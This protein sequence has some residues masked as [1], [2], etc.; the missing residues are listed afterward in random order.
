[1]IALA[2]VRRAN[3][4]GRKFVIGCATFSSSSSSS[5]R[6]AS[7]VLLLIVCAWGASGTLVAGPK[8]LQ[9][10]KNWGPAVRPT[11]GHVWPLPRTLVPFH[12]H[13]YMALRTNVFTFNVSPEFSIT[14]FHNRPQIPNEKQ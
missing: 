11:R 5:S 13:G 7:G 8:K 9:P 2:C 12:H 3:R 14:F 6:K 1:L 10:T 4:Y